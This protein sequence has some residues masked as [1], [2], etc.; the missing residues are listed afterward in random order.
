LMIANDTL[1]IFS[2][3]S[4]NRYSDVEYRLFQMVDIDALFNTK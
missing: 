4:Y 2:V 3:G 1:K